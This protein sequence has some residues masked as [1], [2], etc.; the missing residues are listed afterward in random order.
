M[1]CLSLT[2]LTRVARN[3]INA[4]TVERQFMTDMIGQSLP[5]R[6]VGN[7]FR[8]QAFVRDTARAHF[9]TVGDEVAGAS[10]HAFPQIEKLFKDSRL[11]VFS[12]R[13]D[14]GL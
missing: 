2:P 3:G 13:P 14:L 8:G 7:S 5:S 9:K 12:I 1:R 6:W 4:R 10:S 11:I